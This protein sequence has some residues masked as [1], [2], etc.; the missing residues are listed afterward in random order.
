MGIINRLKNAIHGKSVKA[1]P[2]VIEVVVR[3]HDSKSQRKTN[4]ARPGSRSQQSASLA[5]SQSRPLMDEPNSECP[6]VQRLHMD[7]L[8]NI[9]NQ[10]MMESVHN[11]L[12]TP[13]HRKKLDASPPKRTYMTLP[14]SP[15]S[16]TEKFG[17]EKQDMT[18]QPDRTRKA[19]NLVDM[20]A[21][22]YVCGC[23]RI[24]EEVPDQPLP[25]EETNPIVPSE[26]VIDTRKRSIPREIRIS[27]REETTWAA[28]HILLNDVDESLSLAPSL[29]SRLRRKQGARTRLLPR[30]RV[31][32]EQPKRTNSMR[33]AD[34]SV[35]TGPAD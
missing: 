15:G 14:S 27:S 29:L 16:E 19:C 31:Y 21:D 12:G 35:L 6:E 18:E 2:P 11:D 32:V 5:N 17:E 1:K 13:E 28:N 22:L 7:K 4:N 23:S 30:T 33:S 3:S 24:A 26:V 34:F 9:G 25:R 8:Y 20:L 10:Y